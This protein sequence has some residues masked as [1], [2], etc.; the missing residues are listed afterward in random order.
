MRTARPR[1]GPLSQLGARR[2]RAE[3][4]HARPAHARPGAASRL[5]G[6]GRRLLL[7]RVVA[8]ALA[9]IGAWLPATAA[10]AA[11]TATI[12]DRSPKE[13]DG[14]WKLKM[15]INYGGTPHLSHIPMLFSFTP[16]VHYE[17]ALTDQSPEK[18]ILNRIPLQNQ[19][20]IN[21]SMDVG[22]SDGSGKVFS[23]TK[24]DFVL[25]RDR[26]FEAGEY[27]LVIKRAS[28]GVQ[29]GQKQK[30]T[31]Q[32]ENAIIDRRAIVFTGEKK[33]KDKA[34]DKPDAE[35][36][37]EA[38]KA[39]GSEGEPASEP[40]EAEAPSDAELPPDEAPPPVEPRQGGCGCRLS[41]EEAA[42]PLA[43]PLVAL[44]AAA[45]LARRIRARRERRG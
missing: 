43:L 24:F 29:V 21:E 30:I 15:T 42:T 38:E 36:G 16:T 40:A 31:L 13:D 10:H 32:G 33:K 23:I 8:A 26:G 5:A 9:L 44:G 12:A 2:Q 6:G 19:Q 34:A 45:A 20:S 3:R 17:R 25:R 27:E 37:G 11:G 39:Q 4:P 22:F 35:K 41:P 1:T 14:R 7:A 28:D 18:P